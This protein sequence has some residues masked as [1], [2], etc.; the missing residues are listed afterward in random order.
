MKKI[1]ASFGIVAIASTLFFTACQKDCLHK[2]D[3]KDE[4]FGKEEAMLTLDGGYKIKVTV[5]LLTINE[6]P[7]YVQGR[8]TYSVD[9]KEVAS[10]DFGDAT[11]DEW[12]VLTK[13]GITSNIDLSAKG[14]PWEYTKVVTSP[15][16]KTTGCDYI[17]AGVIE[18]YKNNELIATV[19]YGDG[20]CDDIATKTWPGG[21]YGNK[22]WPGG[23]KTFSLSK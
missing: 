9:D 13:D 22:S 8:L 7:Y 4:A 6:Y 14:A 2:N 16:I 19:D 17:T 3:S 18:Y 12:A 5:P 10:I 20:T 15:L 21:S 23:S 11:K 1:F